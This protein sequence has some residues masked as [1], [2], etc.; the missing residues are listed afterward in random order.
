[1]KDR[2]K[3]SL[4]KAHLYDAIAENVKE[5]NKHM[6][7]YMFDSL[8][9]RFKDYQSRVFHMEVLDLK[10]EGRTELDARITVGERHNRDLMRFIEILNE[11][12]GEHD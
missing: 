3:E 12:I 5:Y 9:Y 7:G 6:K 4:E 2:I 11:A 8:V 10:N 1:M